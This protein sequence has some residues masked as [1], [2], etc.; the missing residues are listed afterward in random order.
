MVGQE[1]GRRSHGSGFEGWWGE[2]TLPQKVLLGIAFG[3][4]GVGL[5]AL[6]GWIVMLLWNWLM[7]DLFGLKPLGYW[8]A[9][10]VL[11]LCTILFKGFGSSNSGRNDRK[12]RR[13]LRQYVQEEQAQ[14][15][16]KA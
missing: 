6:F 4:G 10:G 11:A 13:Q 7:P 1:S 12:R 3:I 8:K 16:E 2:R 5:V 9:W 15:G 14:A